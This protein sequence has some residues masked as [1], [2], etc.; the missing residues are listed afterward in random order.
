MIVLNL[1][2]NIALA[3][4]FMVL[5][6][7]IMRKW[8]MEN[9]YIKCLSGI[10]FGSA[11]LIGMMT[12][13]YYS[14]GIMLDGRSIIL[15][16]AGLYGG[17][18]TASIAAVICGIYRLWLSGPNLLIGIIGIVIAAAVGVIFHHYR[19][20][21]PRIIR[22][23]SLWLF[24]FAL[25]VLLLS[26]NIFLPDGTGFEVIRH[27]S[28]P[29][30]LIYPVATMLACRI[31]LDWDEYQNIEKI[32]QSNAERYK[33]IFNTTL[34]GIWLVDKLGRLKE[35]ND[36]YCRMSG[37]SEAELLNMN[38]TD[39]S[40]LKTPEEISAHIQKI[41]AQ[42]NDRFEARYRRKDGR[43]MDVEISAQYLPG[44]DGMM[45]SFLR[46]VTERKRVDHFLQEREEMF[47]SITENAFDMISLLDLQGTYLYCNPSYETTLGYTPKNLIGQSA[48]PII[49]EVQREHAVSILQEALKE[50]KRNHQ[51]TLPLI[52][53][54]G[55]LKWVDHRVTL[56]ADE[57]GHYSEILIVAHDV[58][59]RKR[60]ENI[61]QS[62]LQLSEFS[63]DHT[64]DELLQKS[65]AEAERLT[66]STISF[67]HFVKENPNTVDLQ[68][69][70]INTAVQCSN[71]DDG[72]HYKIEPASL[73]LDCLNHFQRGYK[74]WLRK[75]LSLHRIASRESCHLPDLG[76]SRIT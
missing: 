3:V 65:L 31:F 10:L 56:L 71:L 53:R 38:I 37:Y 75:S 64:L 20:Q 52:C 1:V 11:C 62:R 57:N 54:D 9:I 23:L 2:Q 21:Y 40:V 33:T 19:Y 45:I 42:G 6:Q 49:H 13:I 44:N 46:D 17:P 5:Q 16:V 28:I 69:W 59:E 27:I 43:L 32:F 73:W 12:P 7:T 35:V 34:D 74:Q 61:L 14:P 48:F 58:T 68:T 25:Q 51:I 8:R 66:G 50:N 76:S 18:L 29:V 60:T 30:L 63:F 15:S 41:T 4:A 55:S 47:R 70:S 67:F 36:V 22:P 24:G 72:S 39:F 26:L